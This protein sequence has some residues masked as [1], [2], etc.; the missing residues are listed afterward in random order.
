MYNFYPI[1]G[2]DTWRLV[3]YFYEGLHPRD[4]LFVQFSCGGEFL[5]KEPEDVMDYLDEIAENSN[6]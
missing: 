2:Y 1:H 3:S 6:T 4:H 5:Q